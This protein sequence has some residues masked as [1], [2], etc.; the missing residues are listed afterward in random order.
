MTDHPATSQD[1]GSSFWRASQVNKT[2]SMLFYGIGTLIGLIIGG[3]GLFNARGTTTNVVPPQDVALVNQVPVLRSD[4][5]IQL[6]TETGIPFNQASREEKLRVLD[7]MVREELMVQRGL[8]LDF[9]ETDQ[10]ARNAL[11]SAV[12]QQTLAEVTTS[13]P[14]EADLKKQYQENRAR[15]AT[16]GILTARDLTVSFADGRSDEQTRLIA[17]QV[18]DALRAGAS[19]E[20]VEA[21]FPV[22]EGKFHDE[23]F[24]FAAKIHM[25]DTL[26]DAVHTL[27]PG[28]VSDP[29]KLED[30]YHVVQVIGNEKPRPLTYEHARAQVLNDYRNNQQSRLMNNTLEFLR[31]RS[32]ILIADDYK[33]DYVPQPYSAGLNP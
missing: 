12:E 29:V 22:T 24:Y 4:F 5:E 8:E 14:T 19:I 15:Y 23:D 13:R 3:I 9:A 16:E 33:A 32:N 21:R 11:Y 18:T 30:G 20:D 1:T 10:A 31:N 28:S 17:N 6:E 2:R 25:G 27:D 26:Y 7:E